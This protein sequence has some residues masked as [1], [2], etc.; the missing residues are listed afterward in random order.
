MGKHLFES[1]DGR[2]TSN[3]CLDEDRAMS[4]QVFSH[5]PSAGGPPSSTAHRGGTPAG[6]WAWPHH[7]RPTRT[8]SPVHLTLR[9]KVLGVLLVVALILLLLP[10]LARGD[11]PD[12]GPAR[13]TAYTVQPGDTLWAIAGRVAPGRD[14]R[15]VVDQMVRDNHLRGGSLQVG[16]QL[17]IPVVDR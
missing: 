5:Q 11:G 1:V 7:R 16:E 12:R 4:E 3:T 6:G 13:T 8:A 2:L 10:G 17:Q 9:A 15:E 14:P